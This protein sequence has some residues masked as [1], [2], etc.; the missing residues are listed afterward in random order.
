MR[1]AVLHALLALAVMLNGLAPPMASAAVEEPDAPV[2][3]HHMG[4]GTAPEQTPADGEPEAPM[5]DCCQAGDCD[6]GCT[7]PQ[8]S[9]PRIAATPRIPAISRAV[10]V[11]LRTPHL[12]DTEGAPFRPP[13]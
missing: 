6:C 5:T 12:S 10:P 9:A 13:A 8:V 11:P 2:S 4:H 1:R 7:A 3:T